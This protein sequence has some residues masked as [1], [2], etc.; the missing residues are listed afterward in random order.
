MLSNRLANA[1]RTAM[2]CL[3]ATVSLPQSSHATTVRMK[4]VLG[5]IDIV[6]YDQDAPSQVAN[7][8]AAVK[9]GVYD[10]SAFASGVGLLG[11]VAAWD[12]SKRNLVPITIGASAPSPR[13]V[14]RRRN[15][16][17]LECRPDMYDFCSLQL[18][19]AHWFIDSGSGE[20]ANARANV[21]G[22]ITA[23]TM[24]IVD[25]IQ[26]LV[27]PPPWQTPYSVYG[28]Y[29]S[30]Q[31]IYGTFYFPL[32]SP[33]A[34]IYNGPVAK[35]NFP[36]ILKATVAPASYQGMWWNAAED[37][38]GMSIMQ[39]ADQIF[40]AIYTYD[41]AGQPVWY[42]MPD[43]LIATTTCTSQ[44]YK[45]NGGTPPT[46]VWNGSGKSVA[47]AGTGTLTF[48]NTNTGKFDFTLNS[49]TGS[50]SITQQQFGAGPLTPNIDYSGMWWNPSEDG[51]GMAITHRA[52]TIFAAWYTYDTAGKPVWYVAPE[53]PLTSSC[54]SKVY[55]VT[56]GSPLTTAWNASTKNVQE[57]GTLRLEF[58]V[59]GEFALMDYTIHGV[60]GSRRII[61]QFY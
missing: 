43:C 55:R 54:T 4:T 44:I 22:E 24:P 27:P 30:T 32:V 42:V 25:A 60:S 2:F 10:N 37:G 49:R 53:C 5:P 34:H 51:W 36:L 18:P 28:W 11:G 9:S 31:R 35:S 40:A 20:G 59:T 56:G 29:D 47:L 50:K 1:F 14:T 23:V 17:V 58:S 46:A 12:E 7:F 41:D 39:H 52:S 19:P 21:F 45:V 15:V 61:P 16:S 8:L 48:S 6:L 3:L 33:I 26:A 57:V 13:R 38:W